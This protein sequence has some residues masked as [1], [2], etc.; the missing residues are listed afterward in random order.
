MIH[1]ITGGNFGGKELKMAQYSHA[2]WR[3]QAK[4]C[5]E[6]M[7]DLKDHGGNDCE[8]NLDV[9]YVAKSNNIESM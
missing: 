3:W 6:D 7:S 5:D 4:K 2:Q 9:L 8:V 1:C